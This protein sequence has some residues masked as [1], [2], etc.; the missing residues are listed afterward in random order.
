MARLRDIEGIKGNGR[1]DVFRVDW[2]A[3]T[4]DPDNDLRDLTTPANRAHIERTKNSIEI[5]GVKDPLTIRRG[6]NDEVFAVD[7]RVRLVS[8]AELEAEGRSVPEYVLAIAEKER[9]TRQQRIINMIIQSTQRKNYDQFEIARGVQ[10]LHEFS[11][12]SQDQIAERIGWKSVGTVKN[13]LDAANLEPE[14]QQMVNDDVVSKTV[15]IAVTREKGAE[16][17]A[18]LK[19]AKRQAE[20]SGKTNQRIT[21]RAVAKITGKSSKQAKTNESYLDF[22]ANANAIAD[23]AK[24][25][26]GVEKIPQE[27]LAAL[28]KGTVVTLAKAKGEK[29]EEPKSDAPLASGLP[30]T[31]ETEGQPVSGVNSLAQVQERIAEITGSKDDAAAEQRRRDEEFEAAAPKP[32]ATLGPRPHNR[33]DSL[34][35]GFIAASSAAEIAAMHAKLCRELEETKAECGDTMQGQEQLCVAADVIGQLRFPDDWDN[36]KATTELAQVA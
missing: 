10:R 21:P 35:C 26:G 11:G 34:L 3:I 19:E 30:G 6:D 27:R 32:V 28:A 1:P 5:E 15:A 7:G 2:H 9:T 23:E 36:A 20:A 18:V 31:T 4:P 24:R 14:I 25:A 12:L 16:A 22:V 13:H 17:P 33:V 29:V 8:L